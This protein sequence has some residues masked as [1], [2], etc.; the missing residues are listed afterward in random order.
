MANQ[1]AKIFVINDG[2]TIAQVEN[3]LN[4]LLNRGWEIITVTTLRGKLV[5]FMRRLV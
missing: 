3:K 4:A 1:R 2:D 5:A